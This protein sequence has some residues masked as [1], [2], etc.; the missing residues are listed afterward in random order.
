M[1]GNVGRFSPLVFHILDH[2]LLSLQL[3]PSNPQVTLS[4]KTRSS[5]FCVCFSL[6]QANLLTILSA[7][8]CSACRSQSYLVPAIPLKNSHHP[9]FATLLQTRCHLSIS[10][11]ICSESPV[12]L[13]IL[14]KTIHHSDK[15]IIFSIHPLSYLF[16]LHLLSPFVIVSHSYGECATRPA[17][18]IP[19]Q[20]N[21]S[22][23]YSSR[24]SVFHSFEILSIH[25]KSLLCFQSAGS[26][27][28]FS[29][30]I[31]GWLLT[32][33]FVVLSSCSFPLS[34]HKQP[35]SSNIDTSQCRWVIFLEYLSPLS[36]SRV[37][38]DGALLHLATTF[39]AS[40]RFFESLLVKTCEHLTS[41]LLKA[42]KLNIHRD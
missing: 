21:D 17:P 11:F 16:C 30:R 42:W 1:P 8:A 39:P 5:V 22:L 23:L 34:L 40:P 14:S 37:S 33:D 24:S 35:L 9:W 29:F 27:F 18:L 15:T 6:Y 19:F 20:T 41:L 3:P 4:P 13:W 38:R 28:P 10:V 12:N 31:R 26:V 25:K 2:T 32:L 7:V 36:I